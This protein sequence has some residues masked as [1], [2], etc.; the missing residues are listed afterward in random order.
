MLDLVL[1]TVCYYVAYRLRFDGGSLDPF[2]Q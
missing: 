2:L 1:I